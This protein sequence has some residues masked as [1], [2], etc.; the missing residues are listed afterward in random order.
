MKALRRHRAA[1]ALL[2]LAACACVVGANLPAYGQRVPTA[3][4]Q[5]AFADF[6][7]AIPGWDYGYWYSG[8]TE[9]LPAGTYMQNRYYIDPL[10]DPANGQ[11]VF[12]YTF[13]STVYQ[14]TEATI[15]G[16]WGTGFGMPVPWN[17]D[18]YT[19]ESVDPYD[20]ILSFDARVEGL[21]P[22]QTTGSCTMEFRLGTGGGTGWVLVKSLPYNA[23]SNWTH[24]EFHLDQGSWIGADQTPTTSLETFTNAVNAGT[25]STVQ[26]NQNQPNP[27]RWGYDGDNA[28]CMDN[29]KLEV[30]HYDAP[31]PPPPP[32]QALPIADYDFD[33][34]N[35]WWAWPSFPETTTGW[36]A[37]ANLATYW[38]LRPDAGSGSGGSNAFSIN[39]DNTTI[40]TDP[41]GTPAW[42]GGNVS[43]G[44]PANYSLVTSPDLKDYQYTFT[45]RVE[46]LAEGQETTPFVVQIYFNAPDDTLQ[47][48]DAD[49]NRDMLVRLNLTVS[50]IRSNW[51]TF[52]ISLKEA[53]VDSGSMANFQ[54]HYSKVD[55]IQWQ[56]QIQNPH[57]ANIWG[58]DADNKII[59]DDFKFERL[60]TAT[61][62]LSVAKI[63][64]NVVVSWTPPST[65]TVLLLTGSNLSNITNEVVGA[66][67]PY[68]SPVSGAPK[69]FRTVWVPPPQ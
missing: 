47:P 36:S 33:D 46:G 68:S 13:D 61:P 37:N 54:A 16:W 8:P 38:A 65:G 27:S 7:T 56:L 14:G 9:V 11:T 48:A 51:Q 34:R 43:F 59:V 40:L 1:A 32:R 53:S 21:A 35:T 63:D 52:V 58:T 67:S 41:P 30:Y 62:P 31:P 5:L 17:G 64:N 20:Y 57:Q 25:I 45:A 6:D 49:A 12:Q 23:G 66:T 24:F 28:V 22:D 60:F 4:N 15:S 55:E 19:F 44:G 29:I 26:F 10:I 18:P 50:N 2:G 3:T 42:A 39:M 69:F